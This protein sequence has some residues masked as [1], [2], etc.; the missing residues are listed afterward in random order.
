MQIFHIAYSTNASKQLLGDIFFPLSDHRAK[1][2]SS[3]IAEQQCHPGGHGRLKLA[4]D[5]SKILSRHPYINRSAGPLGTNQSSTT[6]SCRWMFHPLKGPS[7]KIGADDTS[8][9]PISASYLISDEFAAVISTWPVYM[10]LYAAYKQARAEALCCK[11]PL[12]LAN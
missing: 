2:C 11:V 4:I 10:Q 6:V 3:Y 8:V 1:N 12:K 9:W 7:F 5:A